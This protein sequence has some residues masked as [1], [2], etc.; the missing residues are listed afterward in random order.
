MNT[1]PHAS[2]SSFPDDLSATRLSLV[3]QLGDWDNQ[4]GWRRFFEK[5]HTL[6]LR[7][8]QAAGLTP[9]ESQE[10][11][12]NTI[13]AVANSL[14]DGTFEHRGKGS[15]KAWLYGIARFRILDQFRARRSLA[16]SQTIDDELPADSDLERLWENEWS[17]HRLAI[18]TDLTKAR[19]SARQ[20]QIFELYVLRNW[21]VADVQRSLNVSRPQVYMAKLRV[22]SI[23]RA[24]LAE[25][26]D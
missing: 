7:W 26:S 24:A 15:F 16:N 23:F 6:L 2:P 25:T 22:G 18:A 5:Y 3:E 14:R 11:L 9:H 10:A 20:Y 13:I 1:P 17:H 21:P 12:Q 19:V 8:A 4:S